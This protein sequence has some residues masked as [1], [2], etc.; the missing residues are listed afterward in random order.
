MT[1][2]VLQIG[3][4]G[5]LPDRIYTHV[6]EAILRG[7][8]SATG[9][10]PTEGELASQFAVSR[11]TVR[12]AL[13]R[14]RSDG[15]IESRRGS[16]SH[17][18]RRPGT[19]T[20]CATP[21]RSLADIER[22]YAYRCCIESGAAAAAAEFHDAADLAAMRAEF[23]AL[24]VAME[25]GQS[26]IED[27]VRFHL[28][29]ARASHNPFFVSTIE[30]SVAPIR[31]FME[32]ARSVTDKKSLERVRTVQ[33]E[34]LAIIEAIA[35]RAPAEAA[36]AIRVHVLNAKRRIFEGTQLP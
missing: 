8:F 14:L 15:V 2:S 35:R 34:H 27:D 20:A 30:T 6:V 26:G 3:G 33:A 25:G 23:D 22:Y 31:Q 5:S 24:T 12:E 32:L 29:I 4:A 9:K 19:P 1:D 11:P 28:A 7:D 17:L 36:E 18:L 10:L 21:I 16:G 13:A